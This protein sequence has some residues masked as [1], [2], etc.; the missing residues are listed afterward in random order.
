MSID[1][2][3]FGVNC[4]QLILNQ[5]REL[6][7]K[8]AAAF[9]QARQSIRDFL[10]AVTEDMPG[11]TDFPVQQTVEPSVSGFAFPLNLDFTQASKQLE[12]F[13]AGARE[14]LHLSADS[15]G[16]VPA[17]SRPLNRVQS[18]FAGTEQKLKVQT[19]ADDSPGDALAGGGLTPNRVKMVSCMQ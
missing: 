4:L 2:D 1:I 14:Q 15:S 7:E 11:L 18:L 12:T 8:V 9:D 13:L 19:E 17:A 10:G 6:A 5:K 3:E 16:I